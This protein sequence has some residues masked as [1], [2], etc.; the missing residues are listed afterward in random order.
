MQHYLETLKPYFQLPQEI[1]NQ[2][3]LA[4]V[5]LIHFAICPIDVAFNT[6]PWYSVCS[7]GIY[8]NHTE[9]ANI[10]QLNYKVDLKLADSSLGLENQILNEVLGWIAGAFFNKIEEN[11]NYKIFSNNFNFFSILFDIVQKEVLMHYEHVEYEV[12]KTPYSDHPFL[13]YDLS[14]FSRSVKAVD[15]SYNMENVLC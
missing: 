12:K 13:R 1:Y 4:N 14:P 2:C 3:I 15:A 8:Q 6:D 11:Q 10:K 5:K 9:D 7:D